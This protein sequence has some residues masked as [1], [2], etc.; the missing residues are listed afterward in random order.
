LGMTDWWRPIARR[1]S[2]HNARFTTWGK[3]TPRSGGVRSAQETVDHELNREDEQPRRFDPA[4]PNDRQQAEGTEHHHR[5][6]NPPHRRG[7]CV[8]TG[9]I[10]RDQIGSP[11]VQPPQRPDKTSGRQGDRV[12]DDRNGEVAV[13][14]NHR[15]RERNEG[16]QAQQHEVECDHPVIN[17]NHV[18]VSPPV[19]KPI[20]ADRGEAQGVGKDRRH[21]SPDCGQ[22]VGVSRTLG[23]RRQSN[24]DNQQRDC[25]RKHSV[26]EEQ[27]S[28]EFEAM[29]PR[30][31]V[32]VT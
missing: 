7:P 18:P 3:R 27:G 28:L 5:N 10:V 15:S 13:L 21:D 19:G 30:C 1:A 6:G 16:N 20:E 17:P 9:D 22:E 11:R 25:D 12:H 26:G 14:A 24:L 32:T 4:R 2:W 29:V 8:S 31:E 23:Q